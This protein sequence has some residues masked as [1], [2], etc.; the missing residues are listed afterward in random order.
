M[1][2]HL[3]R[4]LERGEA[5]FP[6]LAADK[7]GLYVLRVTMRPSPARYPTA[8]AEI[9]KGRQRLDIG[10]GLNLLGKNGALKG[11]RLAMEYK[12]P[13]QESLHGIQMETDYT[14]TVGWQK[15]FGG[16]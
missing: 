16:K 13:V 11:H 9:A 8:A 7:A 1:T 6:A 10:V 12:A 14:F 15:A 2:E 5:S 3:G 4:I